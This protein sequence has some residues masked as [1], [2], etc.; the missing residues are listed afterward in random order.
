M[1]EEKLVLKVQN[2]L[3]QAFLPMKPEIP[4]GK[5]I[6]TRLCGFFGGVFKVPDSQIEIHAFAAEGIHLASLIVDDLLDGHE[7]R[8]G[9]PSVAA[10]LGGKKGVNLAFLLISDRKTTDP[11]FLERR[12]IDHLLHGFRE[13]KRLS[14]NL[15]P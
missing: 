6:R 8:R 2:R 4:S 9:K 11:F 1:R 12:I 14:E 7:T 13:L 10:L 3:M 15:R 5:M